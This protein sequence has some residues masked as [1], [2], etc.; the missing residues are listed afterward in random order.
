MKALAYIT[1]AAAAATAGA[2]G[3]KKSAA[4]KN[5]IDKAHDLAV[6]GVTGAFSAFKKVG[7]AGTK[8]VEEHEAKREKGKK[9]IMV[10]AD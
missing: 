2:L 7:E 3:Y 8:A 1:G 9:T 10:G 4:V 6:A 5:G